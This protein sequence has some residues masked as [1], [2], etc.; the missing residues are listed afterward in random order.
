MHKKVIFTP[1][2]P[3]PVGA[4]SQAVVYNDL[5]FVSGQISIDPDT[6]KLEIGDVEKE[7]R[8]IFS[9]LK[10][11]LQTAGSS[12]EKV[13]KVTIYITSMDDYP[14]VDAIYKANF[15]EPFP[16]RA[17]VE[18][19]RLPKNVNVEMDVIAYVN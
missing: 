4:Y 5:L 9:N 2:A 13:L 16:A 1:T 12:L 11:I 3:K 14:K 6:D 19:S 10:N 15:V 17:I 8:I 18:V 7:T